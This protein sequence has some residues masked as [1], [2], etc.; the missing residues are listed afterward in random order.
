MFGFQTFCQP[1]CKNG[2]CVTA[3]SRCISPDLITMAKP[4][5]AGLPLGA[6][7]LGEHVAQHIKAGDHGTTY[8]GGPL[9]TRVGQFVWEAVSDPKFLAH[10]ENMGAL[11]QKRGEELVKTSPLVKE[12]RGKG[13]LKGIELR[14]TVPTSVFVDLCRERGVL[15]VSA[16]SNTIRLI[17]ALIVSEKEI[18]EAFEVFDGVISQMESML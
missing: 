4:L 12:V 5:A 7:V 2:I 1:G 17:P 8:G 6:V 16:S 13:L 14:E 10:V 18:N 3:P 9:A 11:I 15:V